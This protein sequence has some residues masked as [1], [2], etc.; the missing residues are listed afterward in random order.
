V[1]AQDVETF[2]RNSWKCVAICSGQVE[3]KKL[4]SKEVGE[5]GIRIVGMLR[6][7]RTPKKFSWGWARMNA[8]SS[9]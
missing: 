7:I 6:P 1:K 8:P 5:D 3:R 9:D 2:K 4:Y